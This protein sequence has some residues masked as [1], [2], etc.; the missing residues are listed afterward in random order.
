MQFDNISKNVILLEN[1]KNSTHLSIEIRNESNTAVY[2]TT[3]H[4]TTVY[5]TA[6]H[7]TTSFYRNALSLQGHICL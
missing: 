6:V 4:F 1:F 2:F 5:F 3:I 7:F